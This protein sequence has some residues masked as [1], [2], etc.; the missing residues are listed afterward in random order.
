MTTTTRMKTAR[1]A[2]AAATSIPTRTKAMPTTTRTMTT[3][4]RCGQAY[5]QGRLGL[6]RC[7]NPWYDVNRAAICDLMVARRTRYP[8]GNLIIGS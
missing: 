1:A 7:S 5:R 6:L 2:A 4:I 8:H 3:R